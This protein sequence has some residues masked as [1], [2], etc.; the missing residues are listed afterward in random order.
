MTTSA[1]LGQVH[2]YASAICA[3]QGLVSA[4][5]AAVFPAPT[6]LVL[7]AHTAGLPIFSFTA[8]AE[9]AFLP[10]LLQRGDRKSASFPAGRG[11][12]ERL[13]V[14]LFANGVDGVATDQPALAARARAQAAEAIEEN[15]ARRR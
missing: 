7:D 5:D 14:A 8:R 15:R 3:D 12:I 4:P 11:D 10:K 13:L 9:N 2:G 6:T 1:G